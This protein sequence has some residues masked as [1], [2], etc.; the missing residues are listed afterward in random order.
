[1]FLDKLD[2]IFNK[3]NNNTHHKTIKVKPIEVKSITY[4]DFEV[5]S[6]DK[7]HKGYSQ[8]QSEK[9]FLIKHSAIDV[10]NRRNSWERNCCNILL[11]K[12]QMAN[13]AKFRVA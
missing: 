6:N 7:N 1:M 11:K 3:C 10:Y 9:M 8:N 2:Y 13:Q 5:E 4:L 12:W